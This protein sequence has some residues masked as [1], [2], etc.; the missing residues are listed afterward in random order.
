MQ[1]G[2]CDLFHPDRV[3]IKSAFCLQE[4]SLA[5]HRFLFTLY[6]FTVSKICFRGMNFFYEGVVFTLSRP[7]LSFTH[8]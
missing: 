5:A 7:S 4:N 8:K 2:E 3:Q 6:Y 1:Y